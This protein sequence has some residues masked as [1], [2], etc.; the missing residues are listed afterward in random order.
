MNTRSSWNDRDDG[1]LNPSEQLSDFLVRPLALA[2]AFD[3]SDLS[4]LV[5][6]PPSEA[7]RL[8]IMECA[9]GGL[10]AVYAQLEEGRTLASVLDARVMQG[11]RDVN[12][13]R[14]LRD[15]LLKH[16]RIH[17]PAAPAPAPVPWTFTDRLHAGMCAI[18]ALA[19]PAIG[20]VSL[21]LVFEFDGRI[22]GF[23][24]VV[25]ALLAC[26]GPLVSKVIYDQ[27]DSDV[28]R[29]SF[30]RRLNRLA[31][32]LVSSWLLAVVWNFGEAF[33]GGT[34]LV[35]DSP[36][37]SRLFLA[38]SMFTEAICGGAFFIAFNAAWSRHVNKGTLI[39]D[40]D[41]EKLD[42]EFQRLTD[43]LERDE[44]S[45]GLVKS[46]MARLDS[47]ISQ[48]VKAVESAFD[49][50]RSA[51]LALAPPS[52]VAAPKFGRRAQLASSNGV[53]P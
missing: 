28:D 31:A 13:A 29:N 23:R 43:R 42:A 50:A 20:V 7:T 18:A 53:H 44:I 12:V 8:A 45:L 19:M 25:V 6:A 14:E 49:S 3:A 41:F 22:T 26:A 15:K 5:N 37:A 47:V 21:G 46:R 40:P 11:T 32:I 36:V 35:S 9:K 34:T 4:R 16:R 30:R 10:S 2:D 48:R 51:M 39:D 33:S 38:A 17:D 27:L 24:T 52:S 1:R